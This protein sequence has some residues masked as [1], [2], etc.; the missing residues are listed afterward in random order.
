[1]RTS[2]TVSY[3]VAGKTDSKV[4]KPVELSVFDASGRK[5]KTLA[6]GEHE[7]GNYDVTWDGKDNYGIKLASG[8]Y[9]IRMASRDFT[10][11]ERIILLR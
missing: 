7:P 9:F 10:A 4:N 3:S 8:V 2:A 6:S 5:V 1:M 11:N